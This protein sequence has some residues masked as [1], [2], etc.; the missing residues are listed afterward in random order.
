MP[1]TVRSCFCT[2]SS[3]ARSWNSTSLGNSWR[4]AFHLAI[5]SDN[6]TMVYTP[7]ERIWCAICGTVNVP[8][9]GWPPVIATAS[10]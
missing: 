1:F 2:A 9:T 8:S 3:S 5:S 10:L 6:T 7:S 4:R